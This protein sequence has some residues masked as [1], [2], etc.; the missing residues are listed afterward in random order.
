MFPPTRCLCTVKSFIHVHFS[1][2]CHTI[3]LMNLFTHALDHVHFEKYS[4]WMV[5]SS[6]LANP[7]TQSLL[8][9]KR[10]ISSWT[11][12]HSRFSSPWM[13]SK[14]ER[15]HTAASPHHGL[16]LLKN[17]F[18]KN[19]KNTSMAGKG[20]SFRVWCPK[21]RFL[22]ILRQPKRQRC[23]T[24]MDQLRFWG[25]L[26]KP[27]CQRCQT[28]IDQLRFSKN[29][30]SHLLPAWCACSATREPPYAQ[31]F[32]EGTAEQGQRSPRV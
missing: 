10:D 32:Q 26:R 4:T 8:L 22:G 16:L 14:R 31:Y 30:M 17:P 15:I 5:D 29:V 18:T 19:L 11:R 21:I 20:K 13:A 25:I 9:A 27:K 6:Q 23:Q 1:R 12:S 7:F 3:A 28:P 2:R 24:P